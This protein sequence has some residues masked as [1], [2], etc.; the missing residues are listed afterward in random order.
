MQTG[1]EMNVERA[2]YMVKS[3]GQNAGH[4]HNIK[5]ANNGDAKTFV[6]SHN[7]SRNAVM[8]KLRLITLQFRLV[9]LI[10]DKNLNT[11]SLL[12]HITSRNTSN[13]FT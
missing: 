2:T 3:R 13:V 5:R 7:K 1:L 10:L 6:N 9:H 12:Q 8:K 11:Q 4:H